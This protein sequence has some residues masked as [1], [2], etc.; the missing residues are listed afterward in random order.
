MGLSHPALRLAEGGVAG[1][2][3]RV[4]VQPDFRSGDRACPGPKCRHMFLEP[5]HGQGQARPVGL[6]P[7]HQVPVEGHLWAD[8]P[9]LDGVYDPVHRREQRRGLCS[10][11]GADGWEGGLVEE[12]PRTARQ[13]TPSGSVRLVRLDHRV[14]HWAPDGR[15]LRFAAGPGVSRPIPLSAWHGTAGSAKGGGGWG[16][17]HEHVQQ[18]RNGCGVPQVHGDPQKGSARGARAFVWGGVCPLDAP[19]QGLLPCAPAQACGRFRPGARGHLGAPRAPVCACRRYGGHGVTFPAEPAGVWEVGGWRPR[20]G[21]VEPEV[22]P[23]PSEGVP[24]LQQAGAE[25]APEVLPSVFRWTSRH[26][27]SGK[28]AM[29]A[30]QGCPWG[31]AW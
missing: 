8:E 31:G 16:S 24:D 27:S 6:V 20:V 29:R 13:V 3:R 1:A 14:R 9:R 7:L 11:Q 25:A 4:V 15:L 30:G 28:A 18:V 19:V 21:M 2:D 26:V 22:V 23:P 5:R 12:S 10:V 17:Q